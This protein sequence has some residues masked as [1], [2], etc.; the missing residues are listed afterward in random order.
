MILNLYI[1]YVAKYNLGKVNLEPMRSAVSRI[2]E[3]A[4]RACI[5][6]LVAIIAVVCCADL[7]R[8]MPWTDD[9]FGHHI[10]SLLAQFSG[11]LLWSPILPIFRPAL[12]TL[13]GSGSWY[14]SG[15]ESFFTEVS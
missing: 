12:P 15:L 1:F 6:A 10:G 2:C 7:C 5:W 3:V 9:C 11:L 4:A 13:R 14:V 8:S